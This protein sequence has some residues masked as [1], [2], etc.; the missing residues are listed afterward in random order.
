VDQY[1]AHKGVYCQVHEVG[2]RVKLWECLDTG[3]R[4]V[5]AWRRKVYVP[6]GDFDD[7][8]SKV[9]EIDQSGTELEAERLEAARLR[10][11][12][13]SGARAKRTCRLRI[14][15][16][17]A[18]QLLTLTYRANMQDF[19]QVRRDWKAFVRKVA[20]YWPEFR[21]VFAFEQQAR[22]AW[23]VH[24]AIPRLPTHFVHLGQRV[25]SYDLLRRF[26]LA[27]CVDGN[28]D[29]DGHRKNR[30]GLPMQSSGERRGRARESLAKLAG[31]VSKYLTKD[32][33]AGLVGR[34]RWGSTQNIDVPAPVIFDFDDVPL[35]EVIAACFDQRDDEVIAAHRVGSFGK[36]WVLYVE[37]V[38]P[39]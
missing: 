11:L 29:V 8:A 33:G 16:S 3:Q 12:A 20:K 34:N 9:V 36:F 1:V 28:I 30:M 23:H 19:D 24:A 27:V 13:R 10:A 14:K 25:R 22:G 17:G 35:G 37:T 7:P 39:S 18:A 6:L 5:M 32:Y 26:W 15:S 31:Y 2:W 38:P 4:E 21:A